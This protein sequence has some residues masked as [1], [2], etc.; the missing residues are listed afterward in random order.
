MIQSASGLD[1]LTTCRNVSDV[2]NSVRPRPPRDRHYAITTLH[3]SI[4]CMFV[5]S[6]FVA[7]V[8]VFCILIWFETQQ[9]GLRPM[10]QFQWDPKFKR[11]ISA[12]WA[13]S[14][15]SRPSFVQIHVSVYRKVRI[16]IRA[17]LLLPRG[18]PCL[19]CGRD[20]RQAP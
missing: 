9:H 15:R 5:A 1:P 12:C 19:V 6:L 2:R 7:C 18:S 14:P 4:N 16:C 11:L 10:L 17:S 8:F 3:T 13:E 20:V